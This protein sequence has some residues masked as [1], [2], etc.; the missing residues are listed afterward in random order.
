[1]GSTG[2]AA[3]GSHVKTQQEERAFLLSGGGKFSFQQSTQR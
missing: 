1:M 2:A 3:K